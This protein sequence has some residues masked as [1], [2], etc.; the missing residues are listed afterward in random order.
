[1]KN[2]STLLLL[3]LVFCW[4]PFITNAQNFSVSGKIISQQDRSP[5]AFGA[6]S[7]LQLPDSTFVKGSTT[8]LDGNYTIQGITSGNYILKAQ[9]LGFK[10]AFSSSFA[11]PAAGSS[12]NMP[13]IF[14]Q[15][16]VKK[17]EAV[18]VTAEKPFIQQ[19]ADK[20]IYNV[21]KNI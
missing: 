16:D 21:D 2:I 15:P 20:R 18:E 5:V 10:D 19:Q 12:L 13:N 9:S 3:I 6:V 1:M 4:F 7:L 11:F 14:L 17:L 8:D